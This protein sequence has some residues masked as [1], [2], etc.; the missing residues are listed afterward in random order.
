MGATNTISLLRRII[1]DPNCKRMNL[2]TVKGYLG[3][4]IV[5]ESLE[6]AGFKV[7]HQGNQSGYDL[8]VWDQDEEEYTID[9]K[10]SLL[11]DDLSCGRDHWG[12]ALVHS[13]KQKPITATHFVC[14]GLDRDL[15]AKRFI[16]IPQRFAEKFPNGIGQFRRVKHAVCDFQRSYTPKNIPS[17]KAK[18]IEKCQKWLKHKPIKRLG[19]R[20]S[21]RNVFSE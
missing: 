8:T 12:W 4:L 14:V 7:D 10:T 17:E 2:S 21:F 19:R 16:V 18:Y 5:K 9:V 11:K 1:N 20:D 3:E 13:N 6:V 15:E